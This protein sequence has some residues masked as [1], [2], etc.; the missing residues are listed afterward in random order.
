MENTVEQLE[1]RL[2]MVLDDQKQLVK[3]IKGNGLSEAFDKP[4]EVSDT[5]W[6]LISNIEVACDLSSEDSLTWKPFSK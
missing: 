4:T 2:R 3:F 1:H 5:A 6:T